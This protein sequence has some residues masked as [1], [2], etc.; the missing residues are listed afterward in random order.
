MI[1]LE[2]QLIVLNGNLSKGSNCFL[3]NDWKV[4][5]LEMKFFKGFPLIGGFDKVPKDADEDTAV[6]TGRD[7]VL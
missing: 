7:W 5:G 4:H 2:N 6:N 1:I 3:G